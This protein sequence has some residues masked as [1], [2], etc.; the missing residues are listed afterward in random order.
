LD[1]GSDRRV[2]KITQP[3]YSPLFTKFYKGDQTKEDGTDGTCSK[4]SVDEKCL[5]NFVRNNFGDK[6]VGGRIILIP[7][8]NK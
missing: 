7:I 4:H 5:Q 1:L 3:T 6:H 2:K 8:L